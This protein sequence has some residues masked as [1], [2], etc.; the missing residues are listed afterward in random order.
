MHS[1]L[2]DINDMGELRSEHPGNLAYWVTVFFYLFVAFCMCFMIAMIP[3][4]LLDILKQAHAKPEEMPLLLFQVVGL[5]WMLFGV[6]IMVIIYAIWRYRKTPLLF[7]VYEKGLIVVYRGRTIRRIFWDDIHEVRRDV[8]YLV[9]GVSVYRKLYLYFRDH[10]KPDTVSRYI[11]IPKE[12]FQ[13]GEK[14]CNSI[15][16]AKGV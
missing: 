10:E 12:Y 6:M 15:C 2:C 4:W 5:C 14:L 13:D 11:C 16:E 7:A 3:F 8:F 1:L 9:L